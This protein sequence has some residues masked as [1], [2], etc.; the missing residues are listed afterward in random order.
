MKAKK[1]ISITI[2]F[3]ASEVPKDFLTV[4][5][6]LASDGNAF[7]CYSGPDP[8]VGVLGCGSSPQVAM[9]AWALKYAE[10]RRIENQQPQD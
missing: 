4:K 3:D 7:C 10:V 8:Q 5:P 2:E 9:K 6:K 1:R